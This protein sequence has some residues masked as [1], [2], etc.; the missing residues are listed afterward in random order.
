MNVREGDQCLLITLIG[1]NC[2]ARPSGTDSPRVGGRGCAGDAGA[3]SGC[4][5]ALRGSLSS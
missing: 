4:S 3:A 2:R 1:S 5:G